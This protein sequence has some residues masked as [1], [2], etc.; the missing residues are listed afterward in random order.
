M[1]RDEARKVSD[2]LCAARI[3]HVLVVGF[4]GPLDQWIVT[5]HPSLSFAP[6][7]IEAAQAVAIAVGRRLAFIGGHF[8]FVAAARSAGKADADA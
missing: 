6:E 2:A 3:G 7:S 4:H 8:E 1:S 5:L